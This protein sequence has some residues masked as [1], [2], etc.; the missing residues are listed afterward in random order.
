MDNSNKFVQSRMKAWINIFYLEDNTSLTR[1][2]N[3][4]GRLHFT[5]DISNKFVQ[6][7]T[8]PCVIALLR[9][10]YFIITMDKYLE[11]MCIITR[12]CRKQIALSRGIS[13][14]NVQYH[15]GYLGQMCNITRDI[16]GKCAISWGVS[17]A[18]VHYYIASLKKLL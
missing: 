11:Q 13:W 10:Q 7:R 18:N 1:W 4:L 17:W 16:L 14:A 5:R 6:S 8:K 3:I 12:E 15:E 9:G 2:T